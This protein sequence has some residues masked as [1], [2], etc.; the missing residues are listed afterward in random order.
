MS[1]E[2]VG[3]AKPLSEFTSVKHFDLR[4]NRKLTS[5]FFDG[6]ELF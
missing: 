2:Y 3:D 1:S 5:D 4:L 6:L